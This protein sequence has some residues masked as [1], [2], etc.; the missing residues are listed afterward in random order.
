MP[1]IK[2]VLFSGLGVIVVYLASGLGLTLLSPLAKDQDATEPALFN[3]LRPPATPPPEPRFYQARDGNDLPYRAY[4]AAGGADRVLVLI[5]GSGSHSAY[6]ATLARAVADAGLAHVYTPD[7]RGHGSAPLRRG[8]VDHIGQLEED[9]D[10]F[11]AGLRQAHPGATLVLGGHSSGGGLVI[12]HAGGEPAVKAD[13][14]LLLAPYLHHR[15]P[16]HRADAGWAKPNVPR[17][18]GLSL[19]NR[20]GITAFNDRPVIRFNMPRAVRDGTET[21]TYS[22]RLQVSMHPRDDYSADLAALNAPTLVLV[23]ENDE[24]FQADAYPAVFQEAAPD[25]QVR[26]LPEVGHL[27]LVADATALAAVKSWLAPQGASD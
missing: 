22:Y 16:T 13:G 7:L 17:L 6:L 19:L 21:L 26:L 3:G 1:V 8:D 14:Y 4:A 12:R 24:T 15:A 27:D 2:L 9:L 25:A 5:H 10:D 18:I 11:L 20:V 23:G